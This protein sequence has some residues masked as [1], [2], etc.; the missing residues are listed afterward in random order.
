M[1]EQIA[2][3]ALPTSMAKNAAYVRHEYPTARVDTTR[4]CPFQIMALT[5]L[6]D[7][8]HDFLLGSGNTERDAW[9]N[10]ARECAKNDW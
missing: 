2:A 9:A 1:A 5:E 6:H 7:S 10:A 8:V 3:A 4:I